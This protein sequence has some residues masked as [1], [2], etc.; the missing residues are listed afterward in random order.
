MSFNLSDLTTP[1]TVAEARKSVYD[2]LGILG[3]NTTDWRPGAV[4]R[5]LITAF[6]VLFAGCTNLIAAVANG[7]FL[8]LASKAW[9]TLKARYDYNEEREAAT[10][11]TG[12][13]TVANGPD[14]SY[15][16]FDPEEVVFL[17][18][19]TGA[20]YVNVA[21][22]TAG[23]NSSQTVQ[24]RCQQQGSFGTSEAH[25]ITQL[26]SSGLDGLVCDNPLALIG[27][28]EEED[29]P[30]RAK[31]KD[32][33]D[34][35]S[36]DGAIG[37]YGYFARKATR[38]DGTTVGVRRV[39]PVLGADGVL[40]VYVATDS[41]AVPGDADDPNT[42]LGAVHDLIQRKCTPLDTTERTLS[43]A[44]LPFNVN[45]TARMYN[46]SGLTEEQI[47]DY[48]ADAIYAKFRAQPIGGNVT[49]GAN[50]FFYAD[51]LRGAIGNATSP[52][53][54]LPIFNVVLNFPTADVA[55]PEGAVPVVA[56]IFP[57]IQ[58]YAPE[59]L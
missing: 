56:G 57:T 40:R 8:A 13:L 2:V 53:G 22:F 21:G 27:T 30:L 39:R 15:G 38:V 50:G 3:V 45:Y 26:A 17:N 16:P 24:V 43:A 37:A 25:T 5:T 10:Y 33:L 36:P 49:D 41:G 11:A 31:C 4:V 29:E 52:N 44:E 55:V 35:I 59:G 7:G 47:K 14:N 51:D 23:P 42:D 54:R 28:D 32:K 48:I 12:G 9:L 18:P 1:T 34:A 58:Q 46:T 19:L 20:T 6:C